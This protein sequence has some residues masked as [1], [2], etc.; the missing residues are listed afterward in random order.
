MLPLHCLLHTGAPYRQA[1]A[2]CGHQVTPQVLLH[3]QRHE[4]GHDARALLLSGQQ[5]RLGRKWQQQQS[6]QS[7][8]LQVLQAPTESSKELI[9]LH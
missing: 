8:A 1:A 3:G 7:E 9:D 5:R 4:C 2:P 6:Q